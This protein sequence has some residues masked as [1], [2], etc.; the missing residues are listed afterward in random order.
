LAPFLDNS[1]MFIRPVFRNVTNRNFKTWS[2]VWRSF[3]GTARTEFVKRTIRPSIIGGGGTLLA[4][5][6]WQKATEDPEVAYKKK[7]QDVSDRADAMYNNQMF[8]A[9]YDYLKEQCSSP[10]AAGENPELLWRWARAAFEKGKKSQNVEE[11]KRFTFE[12]YEHAKRALEL[13]D[14]VFAA[15]KWYAILLEAKSA[16]EGTTAKIKE[17][18]KIKEH[19]LKA[20]DLNPRDAT[21]WHILGVWYFTIASLKWYERQLASTFFATPP[22]ATYQEA[23]DCFLKAESISPN[24]YSQNLLYLGKTYKEIGDATSAKR[25]LKLAVDYIVVTTDDYT[26]HGE[27]EKLLKDIK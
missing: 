11:K 18:Y 22:T 26:A 5:S 12:A 17:S 16:Y 10:T 25:Y 20:L 27:A 7:I 21:T 2:F 1:E 3:S 13:D 15:H 9:L 19:L 14:K 8:D 6:L 24:F 4:L 23:L